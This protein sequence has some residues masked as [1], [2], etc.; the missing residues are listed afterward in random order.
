MQPTLPPLRGM[1]QGI[2]CEED[3][4]GLSLNRE[5]GPKARPQKPVA[6]DRRGVPAEGKVGK[7][8]ARVVF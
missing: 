6:R 5:G 3:P 8:Q 7:G 4:T 1:S 2:S